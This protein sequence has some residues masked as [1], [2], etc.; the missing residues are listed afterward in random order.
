MTE[1]DCL[2]PCEPGTSVTLDGVVWQE[3]EGG[4]LVVNVTWR[5]KS[6]VGTLLDCTKHD[7]APPRLCDSPVEETDI[8]GKGRGK[9]RAVIEVKRKAGRRTGSSRINRSVVMYRPRYSNNNEPMVNLFIE[10]RTLR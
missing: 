8:K 6:Y 1:A 4:V 9:R 2:G 10:N 5:E 3:T 7:W